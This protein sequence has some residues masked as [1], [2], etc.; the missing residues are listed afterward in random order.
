[1]GSCNVD[2]CC[3]WDSSFSFGLRI[4][5]LAERISFWYMVLFYALK[6]IYIGAHLITEELAREM[7][8]GLITIYDLLLSFRMDWDGF[9]QYYNCTHRNLFSIKTLGSEINASKGP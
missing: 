3:F 1:M 4:Y 8:Y 2:P 6:A 7:R 5:D 9:M